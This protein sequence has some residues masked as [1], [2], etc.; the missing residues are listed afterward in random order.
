MTATDR[1]GDGREE[2]HAV[3]VPMPHHKVNY[4]GIFILL[5]VLTV[6]TVAVAF[7]H[8]ERELIKVLV[9]LT[10]ASVK[11]AFVALYFMHLKFEGKLIYL[12]LF[13]PLLLAVILI[14][15]LIPDITRGIHHLFNTPAALEHDA[16]M[17]VR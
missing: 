17:A 9:A 4:I 6:V 11:A 15:A 12:I 16:G 2:P 3:S 13:V 8:I 14:F 1:I 7:V 5:C 10:I